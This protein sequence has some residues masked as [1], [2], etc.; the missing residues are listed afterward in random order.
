MWLEQASLLVSTYTSTALSSPNTRKSA[1]LPVPY[2]ERVERAL[3]LEPENIQPW[4]LSFVSY[5]LYDLRKFLNLLEPKLPHCTWGLKQCLKVKGNESEARSAVL[6]LRCSKSSLPF[7]PLIFV[8]CIVFL[9]GPTKL[10]LLLWSS[11]VIK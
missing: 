10:L 3:I 8:S 7:L 4:S 11:L 6:G 5:Q 1:S 2:L 9:P